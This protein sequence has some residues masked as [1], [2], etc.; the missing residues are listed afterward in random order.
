MVYWQCENQ[1]PAQ[2]MAHSNINHLNQVSAGFRDHIHN[3]HTEVQ[4]GWCSANVTVSALHM[5]AI[6]GRIPTDPAELLWH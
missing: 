4:G 3:R 5:G 1:S 2:Q 6:I